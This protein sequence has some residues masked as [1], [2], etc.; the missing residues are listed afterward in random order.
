M[1]KGVSSPMPLFSFKSIKTVL[2]F[3]GYSFRL[4]RIIHKGGA[5]NIL[6]SKEEEIESPL[7]KSSFLKI[8]HKLG[9]K[10][11]EP[12]ILSFSGTAIHTFSFDLP[13]VKEEE[14]GS[15]IKWE[16]EKKLPL[17]EKDVYYAYKKMQGILDQKQSF[18]NI[19][20]MIV[21]RDE[22]DHICE[23]LK[24]ENFLV[25]RI[26]LSPFHCL[27][28]L[29]KQK[30]PY[31]TGFIISSRRTLEIY[32]LSSGRVFQALLYSLDIKSINS[33]TIKN[34]VDFFIQFSQK[35]K[36]NLETIY[37][38]N[39]EGYFPENLKKAIQNATELP[40]ESA[41]K[42][43]NPSILPYMPRCL[44]YYDLIG[45]LTNPLMELEITP[46]GA[47]KSLFK[48]KIFKGIK[49]T[50]LLLDLIAIAMLPIL[51]NRITKYN[52][53]QQARR[54]NNPKSEEIHKLSSMLTKLDELILLKKKQKELIEKIKVLENTGV[55]SS[56][57]RFILFDLSRLMPENT[58]IKR[59][60][61]TP[62]K[63]ELEGEAKNSEGVD[64]FLKN[65]SLSKKVKN[66]NIKRVDLNQS[67]EGNLSFILE[68][69]VNQ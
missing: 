45:L 38:L 3:T 50:L 54:E 14:L 33:L 35:N 23:W 37:I 32:L 42:I 69:G 17:P 39:R 10:K 56:R 43:T 5:I 34:I 16:I 18:W 1:K 67:G 8:F 9:I 41:E 48:R 28:V 20:V 55:P 11:N 29:A 27:E 31:L 62:G 66:V 30:L 26:F 7:E 36:K 40:I 60:L 51:S 47:K 63:V 6:D 59:L 68:F 65:L 13:G 19:T 12:F 44:A 2:D 15:L 58:R 24:N 49:I 57:V 46:P 53:I 52:K 22:L 64:T 4:C 21:K 61:I 25:E